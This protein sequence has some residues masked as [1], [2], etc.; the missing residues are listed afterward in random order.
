MTK[1]RLLDEIDFAFRND[2]CLMVHAEDSY[3]EYIKIISLRFLKTFYQ[4]MF[5]FSADIDGKVKV[6][7]KDW[8]Q[9]G[10]LETNQYYI[11]R[12]RT[13]L[14]EELEAIASLLAFDLH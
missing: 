9:K 6:E 7:S 13:V 4:E 12:A 10:T 2:A 11:K 5:T 8:Y 14:Q 1:D 3:T